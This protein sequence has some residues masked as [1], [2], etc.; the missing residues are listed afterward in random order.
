MKTINSLLSDKLNAN[1]IKNNFYK[2]RT[3]QTNT[4]SKI[5]ENKDL[6]VRANTG[7][8]KTLAYL[9]PI[10]DSIKNDI[11]T[12]QSIILT[13]SYE[14]ASQVHGVAVNLCKELDIEVALLIGSSN[15]D[16]QIKK[17]KNKPKIIIGTSG[18]ILKLVSLK[19]LKMHTIKTIVLDEG[20]RLLSFDNIETTK[21]V[22]KKTLR[23]RQLLLF[24][25]TICDETIEK[26]V[27]IMKQPEVINIKEDVLISNNI[28]HH[29]F[30][31]TMRDKVA[32]LRKVI[33][34]YKMNKA[35]VFVGNQTDVNT[36]VDKLNFH[37][38]S[39]VPL[40][41]EVNSIERKEAIQGFRTGK[42]KLLVC[43]DTFSRGLDIEKLFYI[44]NFDLT[45]DFSIYQH[46]VGRIGRTSK[47]GVAVSIIEKSDVG[48]LSFISKKLNIT[49]EKKSLSNGTIVSE[50]NK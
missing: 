3:V 20:D 33:S 35:I 4:L 19:K 26:A 18:R 21:E 15:I 24:S 47:K 7:S 16:R 44:I 30:I 25:A 37:S 49:F 8:G 11:K 14:L 28:E 1:L 40:T 41:G 23:D 5:L 9:L 2:L 6:I 34:A 45:E 13:P 32:T 42:Y 12:P 29:T 36:L 43:S 50:Q 22:I 31:S 27:P 38:K 46:R 39:A 48:S 10:I 17:L